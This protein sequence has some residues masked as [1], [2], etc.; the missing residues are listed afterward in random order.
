MIRYKP[1]Y[2]WWEPIDL[3]RK[4]LLVGMLA[5]VE[6]GS[7]AQVLAGLLCSF[8]FFALHIKSWPFRH[9]Q[10]NILKACMEA[11]IFLVLQLVL[12]MKTDLHGEALLPGDYDMLTLVSF[13]VLVPGGV[14]VCISHKCFQYVRGDKHDDNSTHDTRLRSAFKRYLK[15]CDT[16]QDRKLLSAEF[17]K[18]EEEVNSSFHVFISYRV[19]S[20][21][22][23]AK[24]LFDALSA[25]TIEA[26]GQQLRVYLDQ[27]RLE[28][29]ERWDSA[30]MSGLNNSWIAV[31]IVSTEGLQPMKNLNPTGWQSVRASVVTGSEEPGTDSGEAIRT[32]STDNVLLELIAALEVCALS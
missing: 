16:E 26:T 4:L 19:S 2:F 24:S 5:V 21:K 6:R 23:F 32:D 18:L 22:D 30:F 7:V 10:D 9:P 11:H 13:L 25:I 27:V 20:E 12:T 17:K 1:A 28:D 15:A 8:V 31:P 14:F 29:G 3:L